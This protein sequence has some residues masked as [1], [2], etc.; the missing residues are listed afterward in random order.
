MTDLTAAFIQSGGAPIQYG[1]RDLRPIHWLEVER[2][3]VI[4]LRFLGFVPRPVQG[5]RI[6]GSD[7]RMELQ[8]AGRSAGDFV[9]WT[10]SA[11]T[12]SEVLV[13]DARPGDRVGIWNV[14]RDEKF[15][16]TMYGV[17]NSA[18]HVED[19]G[20]SSAILHC[21]D[22]VGEPNFEDLVVE[23]SIGRKPVG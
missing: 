16:A 23:V 7:T 5:I 2:G 18:I 1:G 12:A 13:L 8:T 14:W 10:D 17:N 9:F 20:R 15:G 22:G 3:D 11:P 4:Q 6:G 21:S 19:I